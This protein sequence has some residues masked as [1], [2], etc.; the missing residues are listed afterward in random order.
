MTERTLGILSTIAI[1]LHEIP[2][3]LGLF[4]V[5]IDRGVTVKNAVY[6]NAVSAAIAV[7]GTVM[8]LQIGHSFAM[9][10]SFAIPVVAGMFLYIACV[11]LLPEFRTNPRPLQWKQLLLATLSAVA[12]LLA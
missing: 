4:G 5:S 8:A 9:Y 1:L 6:M 12:V 2:H 7:V 11:E 3:E 10:S